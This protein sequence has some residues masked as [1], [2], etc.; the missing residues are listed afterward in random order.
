MSGKKVLLLVSLA[1]LAAAVYLFGLRRDM[2]DF[3]V[4]FQAGGRVLKGETLYRSSDGHLQFKYAPAAALVYAPLSTLPWEAAKAV[5]F[6]VMI[7][8]LAGLLKTL[9]LWASDR[10][11][12]AVQPLV[13]TV[14]VMAKCLGR[15]FQ[16][17][18]VNVMILFL[19]TV[20]ARDAFSGR[21]IRSGLLWGLSILFKPYG[22]VFLPYLVL[23]RKGRTLAFG[24]GAFLA[25][26]LIPAGIYG[27]GGNLTVLEEWVRTLSA[28]TPGLLSVGDN[29]SIFA[30]L[31]KVFHLSSGAAMAAGGIVAAGLGVFLLLLIIRGTRDKI[32]GAWFAETA[33]LMMFI[34]LLSPL[35]WN[36]NYL[37]G[38][39]AVFA[40]LTVRP[41]FRKGERAVSAA[42]FVLIG[43]TLRETMGKAFFRYY[44]RT[45]LI[46]PSFLLVFAQ[47]LSARRRRLL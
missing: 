35:G 41:D 5:W 25:G 3:R 39:P 38:L 45:A 33:V 8:G 36:Y 6:V 26:L 2:S 16:L 21:D 42:N 17:G 10:G 40:L 14:V 20:A 23:K 29:A 18:Q 12:S 46:V 47:L 15:E 27:F 9:S 32:S 44:T 4:C 19:L 13:W 43:G 24:A 31:A 37:Y 22:L 34:P 1:V 30:F 11:R 28:S 7:L